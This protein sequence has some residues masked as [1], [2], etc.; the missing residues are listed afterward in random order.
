MEGQGRS[1]STS[2]QI[3]GATPYSTPL[4]QAIRLLSVLCQSSRKVAEVLATSG[5]MTDITRFVEAGLF[6]V[7]LFRFPTHSEP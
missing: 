4:V 7:P 1:S 5:L 3:L 6:S 2:Y